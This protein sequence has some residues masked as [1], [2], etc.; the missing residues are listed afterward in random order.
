MSAS[1]DGVRIW[2]PEVEAFLKEIGLPSAVV[3]PIPES[4]ILHGVTLPSPSQFAN[5]NE[6]E[7]AP[8][9]RESGQ[10]GYA[11]FLKKNHPRAFA[12][13]SSCGWGWASSGWEAARRAMNSCQE[14][15]QS[16]PCR[17][18]AIDDEVV[19]NARPSEVAHL[20]R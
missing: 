16:S 17:T 20:G 18:Y 9:L 13:S 1:R 15:S 2:L 19:W 14:K 3:T 7:A 12:I 11:A 4:A 8:Y 6:V 10:K 5:L